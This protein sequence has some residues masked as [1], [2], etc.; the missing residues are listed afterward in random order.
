MYGLM[1][2]RQDID[3]T[4][5]DEDFDLFDSLPLDHT[6]AID[7]LK[8]DGFMRFYALRWN[9]SGSHISLTHPPSLRGYGSFALR[10]RLGS[11]DYASLRNYNEVFIEWLS[12]RGSSICLR[13][14]ASSQTRSRLGLAVGKA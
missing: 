14:E 1:T 3:V 6:L 9:S 13:R 2:P 8:K 4:F 5:G 12:D 7:L 10:L 11:K